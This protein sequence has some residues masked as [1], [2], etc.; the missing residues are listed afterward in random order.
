MKCIELSGGKYV[1]IVD[2]EIYKRVRK[3]KWHAHFSAG[4]GKRKGA[5]YARGVVGG[6]KIFLHRFIMGAPPGLH[7]DHLNHCTLDCRTCNLE[8][9][10]NVENNRRRR[11]VTRVSRVA[12][13]QVE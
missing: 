11:C 5:P 8:V 9:V 3:Y 4:K 6:K 7:V 13:E 12:Q 1:A 10:D 2:D